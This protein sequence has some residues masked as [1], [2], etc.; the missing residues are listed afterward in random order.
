M[1]NKDVGGFGSKDS[2]AIWFNYRAT[3]SVPKNDGTAETEKV[4]MGRLT[5]WVKGA[6]GEKG[7]EHEYEYISGRLRSV[8]TRMNEGKPDKGVEAYNEMI[9]ALD[10]VIQGSPKVLKLPLRA[11][12]LAAFSVLRRLAQLN[13]GDLVEISAFVADG[14]PF[15]TIKRVVGN[16]VEAIPAMELDLGFM[17][18]EGLV[19]ARLKAARTSN[20][21]IRE[22][23]VM[24]TA[25]ALPFY[26]DGK[27]HEPRESVP[28]ATSSVVA[29]SGDIDEWDPF[30]ED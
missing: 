12:S 1:S 4:A 6:T 13:K 14:R 22:E 21:A 10:A 28:A 16:D 15:L 24:N 30:A 7:T 19:G 11:G 25:I 27:T 2:G 8:A 9:I 17:P 26:D 5:N 20:E 29:R 23:W 3:R 18:L